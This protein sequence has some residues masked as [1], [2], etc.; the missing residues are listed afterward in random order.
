L[1]I[2]GRGA[3]GT[4]VKRNAF[5]A[6]VSGRKSAA[7]ATGYPGNPQLIVRRTINHALIYL[8][9]FIQVNF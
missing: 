4:G 3:A 8:R 9:D 6:V 1:A 5:I 2:D 7:V